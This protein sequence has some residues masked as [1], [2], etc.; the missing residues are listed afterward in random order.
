MFIFIFLPDHEISVKILIL[1]LLSYVYF[2]DLYVIDSVS[3]YC[4]SRSTLPLFWYFSSILGTF[5]PIMEISEDDDK[6]VNGTSVILRQPTATNAHG[7]P[8][9][10]FVLVWLVYTAYKAFVFENV[11]IMEKSVLFIFVLVFVCYPGVVCLTK[12]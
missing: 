8:F 6:R 7:G 2:L 9:N 10:V 1:N 11:R 3:K 4:G 12:P 5:V